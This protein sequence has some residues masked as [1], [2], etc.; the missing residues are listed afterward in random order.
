[1]WAGISSKIEDE[2]ICPDHGLLKV[3]CGAEFNGCIADAAIT[4]NIGEDKGIYEDL[5]K[6]SEDGL[7]AALK[8]AGP[9]VSVSEIGQEIYK[10][11]NKYNV[12]PISNLGGHGLDNYEIHDSPF[13]P[14]VPNSRDT[15]QLQEGRAYAI[16][17]FTTNGYGAINPGK[18][19]NIFEFHS[20]KKAKT[21]KTDEKA[22]A[23]KFRSKFK[24]LPFSPRA[25][26][27]L[28][29][30]DK[31]NSTIDKFTKKGILRGY[32]IFEEIGGGLVAQ[33]EHS[34]LILKDGVHVYTVEDNDL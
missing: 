29:G 31:I 32:P 34:I 12:K 17:P 30:A 13:I 26:D 22:L 19:I 2:T 18:V 3:D 16:E 20:M 8:T 6:A 21:L 15:S 11:I 10:A 5:V 14:N 28:Q 4:I 23:Q 7:T 25:V 24:S 9:G 27:F 33:T 1:M